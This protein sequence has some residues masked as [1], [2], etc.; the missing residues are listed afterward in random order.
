MERNS[1]LISS[2]LLKDCYY[3]PQPTTPPLLF[4]EFT[5]QGHIKRRGQYSHQSRVTIPDLPFRLLISDFLVPF[6]KREMTAL[7]WVV[8][9]RI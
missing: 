4:F 6:D 8:L 7:T 3:F 5:E 2:S 9:G 1:E